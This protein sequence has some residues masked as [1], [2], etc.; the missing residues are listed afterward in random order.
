MIR[1]LLDANVLISAAVRP[2]GPPGAIAVAL[3]ARQAFELVVSP[4]IIAE[5]ERAFGQARIRKYFGDP[6]DAELWLA[7]IVALA[8]IVEDTGKVAGVCRDP[9]DDMV[10]AAALEGRAD[11]IVTG[12][13]D[14]LA[15]EEYEGVAIVAPRMFLDALKG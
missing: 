9:A 3:L 10:L 7:D 8:D 14:L 11:V 6:K 4:A 15:L 2:G 12:D 5:V 13:R 1:A